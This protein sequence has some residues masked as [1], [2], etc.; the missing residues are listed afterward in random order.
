M[1]DL[2]FSM[3]SVGEGGAEPHGEVSKNMLLSNSAKKL[4][5]MR[6]FSV[7]EPGFSKGALTPEGGYDFIKFSEKLHEIE[8]KLAARSATVFK[9]GCP[10]TRLWI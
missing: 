5:E 7:A 1:A 9:L 8:N 4:H 3:R 2:R 6:T 10:S